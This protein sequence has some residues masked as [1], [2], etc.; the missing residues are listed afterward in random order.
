MR[1][2]IYNVSEYHQKL[3]KE[4]IDICNSLNVPVADAIKFEYMKGGCCAGLCYV[5][6]KTICIAKW[7]PER[8]FIETVIHELLHTIDNKSYSS[9]RG[10]WKRWANYISENSDYFINDRYEAERFLPYPPNPMLQKMTKN[11]RHQYIEKYLGNNRFSPETL[12]S[13]IPY[14]DKSDTRSIVETLLLN[15]PLDIELMQYLKK[16]IRADAA[17]FESVACDYCNEHFA[18]TVFTPESRYLF[19]MIF[20]STAKYITVSE[21]TNRILKTQHNNPSGSDDKSFDTNGV[22]KTGGQ[23]Y[24]MV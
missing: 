23:S 17:L 16:S 2:Y 10:I 9:H 11:N 21:H 1:D 24:G 12:E 5:D 19:D 13:F 22:N 20:A 3:I 14:A 8:D 15:F 4:S 18:K 7:L 6:T